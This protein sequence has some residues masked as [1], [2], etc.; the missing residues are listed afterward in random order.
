MACITDTGGAM[1]IH[2]NIAGGSNQRLAGVQ[3]HAYTNTSALGPRI[4]GKCTLRICYTLHGIEGAVERDKKCITLLIH[5][6]PIPFLNGCPQDLMM[7]CQYECI[8]FPQIVEQMG[9]AFDIS[10]QKSD[11][12]GLLQCRTARCMSAHAQA[13]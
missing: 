13:I 12:A 6:A 11:C 9:G 4:R 3:A 5:F 7:L 2:A 8:M 1:H 10:K